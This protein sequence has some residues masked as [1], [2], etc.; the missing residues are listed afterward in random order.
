MERNPKISRRKF[1]EAFGLTAVGVGLRGTLPFRFW[2]EALAASFP[3]SS[4]FFPETGFY[5]RDQEDL[6]FL[7]EYRRFGG[8]SNL[9]FPISRV[10]EKD[11]FPH[12][13]FQR[14]ILQWREE[15]GEAVPVNI[16]D[17]LH[18]MGADGWLYSLGVPKHRDEDTSPET[19][20][21]WL[22]HP[23]IK[24]AYF[25]NPY[26]SVFYGLPTSFPERFGHFITQ[27]LQRGVLQLWLD[28]VEGMPSPLDF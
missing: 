22:T 27:R 18:K 10:F 5:V 3:G 28:E 11:G 1:L 7:S 9:G 16:M 24:K 2:P 25:A 15:S 14:A 4:Q 20:L 13:S 23:E 12:Q 21:S 8:L 6:H 26:P 19:R 17:E